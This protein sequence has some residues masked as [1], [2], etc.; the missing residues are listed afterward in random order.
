MY[1][2]RRRGRVLAVEREMDGVAELKVE[3]E[4]REERALNYPVLTGPALPGDEVLLNVTAVRLGLGTG[5]YHFVMANLT[6]PEG[7]EVAPGHIMKLRY[8]P[9]QAAVLAAEEEGSPWREAMLAARSLQ[10]TPVIA[11]GLHSQLGPAAAGVKAASVAGAPL[12]A[13]RRP[14]LRVAYVQT[15]GGA[16]SLPFSRLVIQ[17]KQ[18]GFIDGAV[19]AGQAWGGDLEAVN[20]YSGLLAAKEVFRAEVI[21]AG[22]GPGGAGTGSPWGFSAVEQG[23]IINAVAALGGRPLAVPRLSTADARARHRGISH[24]TLT[25]LGRVALAPAVVVF[26]YLRGGP[27]ARWL[28][29]ARKAGLFRLHRPALADGRPALRALEAAGIEIESMGRKF[30]D[31]PLFFLA[32]GAA[33]ALAARFAGEI[34]IAGGGRDGS[35]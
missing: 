19:S 14:G 17:L 6:R 31:D 9:A 15:E 3:V 27:S 28:C 12:K 2:L 24:H 25:A 4:G 5:G 8:T 11:L 21:I 18:K 29:Q 23:Q 13:G 35:S 20:L 34:K 33:G 22:P 7:G 10:G 30:I 26:P 16:L 32:A 1:L